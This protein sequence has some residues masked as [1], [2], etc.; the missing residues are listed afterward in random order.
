M[1]DTWALPKLFDDVV[2]RFLAEGNTASNSFGWREPPRKLVTGK[3]IT[4][5][6][7]NIDGDLGEIGSARYPGRNPRPLA[8]LHEY[9]TVEITAADAT[10]PENERLQYLACR[11]LYDQWYRA[12]YLAARGTFK[13]IT[14]EWI[15]DKKERRYGAAI[16]VVCSIEAMIPDLELT[17][18]PV[19][20]GA[21]IDVDELDESES[22]QVTP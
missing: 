12:V 3:R 13:I 14:N 9:F 10:S 20:T 22:F 17:S 8:T 6:P 21:D 1:A 11:E 2:A 5:I 15:I 18:A 16:R 4:W 7:G 19:D